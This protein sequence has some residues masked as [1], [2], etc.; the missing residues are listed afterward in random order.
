MKIIYYSSH[1][2]LR[3]KAH[4]GPGTHMRETISALTALGHEVFP[5]IMGDELHGDTVAA[6]AIAKPSQM[7]SLIKW[8]IP[9]II[10][11]TLKEIQLLRTDDMAARLLEKKIDEI[12]PDL[13]YERGAYLQLSGVRVVKVKGITHFME[14]NAPFID[15]VRDFEQA[16][17]L[18][19]RKAKRAEKMQVQSPDLVY[20][21]SSA[22]KS[23]YA[24]FTKQP[25]KILVV[26]NSV[27]PD[28]L[29]VNTVA[30]QGLMDEYNLHNKKIIGFVG[31]IFP[32]HGVDILIRAFSKIAREFADVTLLIVGDGII[33]NDLKDL[34]RRE[35]M[36]ERILF[37]GSR[38]HSEVFTWIDMMDICVMAKSNWY[39]SPVK[40]FEYGAM[41]K[42]IV[43][44]NTIPVKDVME[45][46]VDGILIEPDEAGLQ[47]ALKKLLED[48]HLRETLASN[49]K[50]KV[51]TTYT[52]K[53]TAERIITDFNKQKNK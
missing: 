7:R 25:E 32:Y 42:G 9:K 44:P 51:L 47:K 39:G 22:L 38:A 20:V 30:R 45:N 40:I 1:P 14:L 46:N 49:F 3:L 19:L 11:R 29:K 13:V 37:A 43:A 8:F 36:D 6:G 52:W 50:K 28:Y 4:S 41:G 23:Y 53:K 27:N 21:V 2:Q 17:T 10:W 24:S 5:V 35:Q 18:L 48:N 15:E 33:L 26:P 34:S 31:S 16:G 12:N